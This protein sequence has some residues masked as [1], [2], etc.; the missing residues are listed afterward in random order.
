MRG[1]E[2]RGR[3]RRLVVA[4]FALLGAAAFGLFL[5]SHPA[6][7][8][9]PKVVKA[10]PLVPGEAPGD[11]PYEMVRSGRRPPYAPLV[12]FDSLAG[13]TALCE[14]GAVAE[15]AGSQKQR[16]WESPVAKVVYRGKSPK[17][18]ITLRPP[19]PVPIPVPSSAVAVWIYGNNWAWT[20]DPTTPRVN[21]DLLFRDRNG[22]EQA[23]EIVQKLGWK[24]WWLVHRVLPRTLLDASPLVLH[25]IRI[26]GCANSQ[27][28][29]LYFEDL[30][31]IQESLKPLSFA[32]RPKRGIDPFPGQDPGPNTGAGRLPFPTREETI[33]P[34]NRASGFE[35]K[36]SQ[37]KNDTV[38]FAYQGP[39]GL[40][41]Y[42]VR[43]DNRGWGPVAVRLNEAPIARALV[44]AGPVF[45][46]EPQGLRLKSTKLESGV[47][48]ASWEGRDPGGAEILIES[49]HAA[50]AEEPGGGLLLSRRHC[51]RPLVR[52]HSGCRK[53][54]AHPPA[55]PK[56]WLAPS[57][58]LDVPWRPSLFCFGLDGLVPFKRFPAIR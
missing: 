3:R 38:R 17:S 40:L 45:E 52:A 50:V 16:V 55:L 25:G 2:F 10:T 8:Q 14:G 33:L 20:P 49:A 24:E 26:T 46:K 29:E 42:D 22:K 12:D 41:E 51:D 11:R 43:P 35:T 27:N 53:T 6:E 15:L 32:P 34:E 5:P 28:R 1:M 7:A 58:R 47:V 23:L 9:E 57:E 37:I 56:L 31:F 13:W 18:S 39:D 54:G 21:I 4:V 44:G 48:Q 36:A 19:Q 30:A